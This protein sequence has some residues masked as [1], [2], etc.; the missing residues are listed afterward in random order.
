M[1]VVNSVINTANNVNNNNNNNNN[2][3]N[4]N[5]NNLINV[6]IANANNNANNMNTAMAG[7]RRRLGKTMKVLK[8]SVISL[9]S[10]SCVAQPMP[11]MAEQDRIRSGSAI[12]VLISE[13]V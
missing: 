9:I 1:A 7:R 5:N 8:S 4:D 13:I 3:D 11:S 2:N 6:N 10:F 12:L